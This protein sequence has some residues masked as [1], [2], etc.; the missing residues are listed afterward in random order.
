MIYIL[1]TFLSGIISSI[2]NDLLSGLTPLIANF[3]F[4]SFIIFNLSLVNLLGP[5]FGLSLIYILFTFFCIIISPSSYFLLNFIPFISNLNFLSF[6]IF[7][8]SLLNLFSFI[9]ISFIAL[10][11]LYLLPYRALLSFSLALVTLVIVSSFIFNFFDFKIVNNR[12]LSLFIFNLSFENLLLSFSSIF[13]AFILFLNIIS[14]AKLTLFLFFERELPFIT[15]SLICLIFIGF[16]LSN[17]FIF[18]ILDS[19][20]TKD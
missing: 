11:D 16:V 7:N 2:I 12:F 20:L 6:I 19:S 15:K 10:G 8:L 13:F 5:I 1:F 9:N 3:C 14:S 18:L 17:F 4:L